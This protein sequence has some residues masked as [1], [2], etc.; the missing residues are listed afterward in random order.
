MERKMKSR[1][2]RKRRGR[3]G[4]AGT[5]LLLF[6][7]V[8]AA[9]AMG[10]DV[11]QWRGDHRDGSYPDTGLLRSWPAA[12]P[13]MLWS[14]DEAGAG[15]S[16]PVI[17]KDRV[18]V[19]GCDD[20]HEYL[21]AFDLAGKK[22]W[23]SNY[24]DPWTDSYPSARSTPTV[25]DG[26]VYVISATGVVA[27][28][29]GL[30]GKLLWSRPIWEET[31]AEYGSWGVS[32]SPLV[33]DGKVIC[34]PGA[35][36][37]SVMALDAATG[38]TVWKSPSLGDPAAY[39]SPCLVEWKG[40]KQIVAV[41]ERHIFGVDP[42]TGAIPWKVDYLAIRFDNGGNPRRHTINCNTPLFRDGRVFVT[43][44]YDHGC[45]QLA[46]A[47]DLQSVKIAWKNDDLDVHHGHMVLLGDHL[48]GANW[49][50]NSDGHWL[51]LDWKTGK[52]RYEEEWNC[53]GAIISA[54]GMLYC[55][56]ER[57]G[58]LALVPATPKGF[59]PVSSFR[60]RKGSDKHWAHPVICDGRLYHRHGEA[61]M[62]FDLRLP[63]T[64]APRKD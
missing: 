35:D 47:D 56:E 36:S 51:C 10:A 44:G 2:E 12:G 63:K 39:V 59:F 17:V 1:N 49:L 54:D 25:V 41:L 46:M 38:K 3:M 14:N 28:L 20:D 40:K 8:M 21:G 34:C 48:Y 13:P 9:P 52:K 18:Y 31:G 11:W 27:C 7:V 30:S 60:I 64:A 4:G 15:Y 22:L 24:S 29:D 62:V 5:L 37:S 23:R 19:T 53:K 57:R 26:K 33:V 58:N 55:Y 6:A 16:S 50:N 45:V 42:A 32:E 61:L 43:S